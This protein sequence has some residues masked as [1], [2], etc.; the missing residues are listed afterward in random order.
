[1]ETNRLK[2]GI[3][4]GCMTGVCPPAGVDAVAFLL[5][6]HRLCGGSL[7]PLCFLRVLG[8]VHVKLESYLRSH[9]LRD[10]PNDLFVRIACF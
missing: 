9:G 7:F 10:N 6:A 2:R 4:R 1:M 5:V 8:L 3:L